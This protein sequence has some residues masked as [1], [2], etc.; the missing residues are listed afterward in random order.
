M[1]KILV[2]DDEQSIMNSVSMVLSAEGYEID[3]CLD[4]LSALKKQQLQNTTLS[5]LIL[6]CREWTELKF[7][8]NNG[9]W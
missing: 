5:C 6:K 1:D 3:G 8:K 9:T 2:V 4:G 7:W